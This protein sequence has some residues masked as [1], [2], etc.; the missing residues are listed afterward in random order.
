VR[1][2]KRASGRYDH[3]ALVKSL[4]KLIAVLVAA[5]SALVA[6]HTARPPVVA[7]VL[8]GRY[9]FV[10]EDPESRPTDHNLNR[11][12]LQSDGTYDL[13][14]G[15]TT[16]PALEKKGVWRI[17]PG[18][19]PTLLLDRAGYPVEIK[20]DEVRLLVDLDTGI[21]WAKNR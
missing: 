6:C 16:K 7:E 10:S 8:V 12:D 2:S 11:L 1:A 9:S 3:Y 14:E 15:G 17:V 21:W 4:G 13:V 19:P 20:G 5:S 18:N